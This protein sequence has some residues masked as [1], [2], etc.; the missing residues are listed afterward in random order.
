MLASQALYTLTTPSALVSIFVRYIHE[1]EKCP[2]PLFL[3][4]WCAFDSSESLIKCNSDAVG[5][6]EAST[7]LQVMLMFETHS[8]SSKI[9]DSQCIF[10]AFFRQLFVTLS[11]FFVLT[12]IIFKDIV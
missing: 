4:L 1:I 6:N 2:R 11:V 12:L 8:I 3:K 10:T 7:S 9:L 5:K